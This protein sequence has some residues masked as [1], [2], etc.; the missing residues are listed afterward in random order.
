VLG[1][2][3]AVLNRHRE[4]VAIVGVIVVFFL[5]IGGGLYLQGKKRAGEERLVEKKPRLVELSAV[6]P[7]TD[8]AVQPEKG[9]DGGYSLTPSANELLDLLVSLK[10]L[11]PDVQESRLQ[12]LRVLWPLYFFRHEA[13]SERWTRLFFDAAEDG[14]GAM[15]EC[16]VEI[17]LYPQALQLSLGEK[18]WVGG[19]IVA[20]DLT[21]TGTI[22][23]DLDYLGPAPPQAD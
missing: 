22:Y 11:T 10:D 21:G 9:S 13:A 17:S 15:I 19:V 14:F 16:E 6:E 5:L 3:I 23:L 2:F 20:A 8:H 18:V 12:E 4:R 7:A 1:R